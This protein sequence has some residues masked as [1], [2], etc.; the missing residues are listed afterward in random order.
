MHIEFHSS[1]IAIYSSLTRKKPSRVKIAASES[2]A[3]EV[4]ILDT[5]K[6]S[7]SRKEMGKLANSDVVKLWVSQ[8][9]QL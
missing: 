8:P 7:L 4:V 1:V 2:M 9:V 5:W 6:F 3:V